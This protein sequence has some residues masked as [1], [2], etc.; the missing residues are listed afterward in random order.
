MASKQVLFQAN[1]VEVRQ[2]AEVVRL[3]P[4][5]IAD[6]L[7]AIINQMRNQ[8]QEFANAS[9]FVQKQYAITEFLDQ[10]GYN[11]NQLKLAHLDINWLVNFDA[12]QISGSV[13]YKFIV[14]AA[15]VHQIILD[16]NQLYIKSVSL[17]NVENVNTSGINR[18]DVQPLKFVHSDYSKA[19]FSAPLKILLEQPVR[20][21]EC[22]NV[23]VEYH[24]VAPQPGIESPT[25]TAIQWLDKEQTADKTHPYMFTQ[26]QAIHCRSLL[27]CFDTPAVKFT[28]TAQVNVKSSGIQPATGLTALMSASNLSQTD[29][30]FMFEQKVPIPSYLIALLVGGVTSMPYS[31]HSKVWSEPSMIKQ[32]AHEFA[33]SQKYL[34]RAQI[35]T[36]VQYAWS[37]LDIVVLPPS[38]PYGG[39][40]NTQLT[41][42]TNSIVAGDRSLVDV[43]AHEISHSWAG[44]LVGCSSWEHFWLNEGWC[45]YLE[46]R[47]LAFKSSSSDNS[48]GGL[49]EDIRQFSAL[50]GWRALKESCKQMEK[51]GQL[52]LTK[53]VNN[54]HGV[55]PDDAFSSVPYEKGFALLYHIEQKLGL[56][57]FNLYMKDYFK[58][59]A[60]QAIDTQTWKDHLYEFVQQLNKPEKAKALDGI[61]WDSWLNGTGMPLQDCPY[62]SKFADDCQKLCDYWISYSQT[63]GRNND[64]N[65]LDV[66]EWNRW[67]FV[68]FLEQLLDAQSPLTIKTLEVMMAKL[69]LSTDTEIDFDKCPLMRNSEIRFR[70]YML[71]L[72]AQWTVVFGGVEKFLLMYGRMKFVR[73]LMRAL[74][75]CGEAGRKLA[76]NAL[77]SASYHSICASLVA[78]DLKVKFE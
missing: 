30:K 48:D 11:Y 8:D 1:G 66:S 71:C 49:D 36:G 16:T 17:Q 53:L 73:P 58:T 34:E 69:G 23:L 50:I 6:G 25:T 78:K 32:C 77:K 47:V 21:G 35:L 5:Q 45:M 24:T 56:E 22:L 43:V 13:Q 18:A 75:R 40:E 37:N 64:D 12:K 10:Q 27:P 14:S 60:K 67:Q 19:H 59:F 9:D 15:E 26:C 46:R 28:W 42:L 62:R 38:F 41:F 52:Q 65:M 74:D 2:I 70:W 72:N 29:G 4:N 55:D 44:N 61:N 3:S 31:S 68:Y 63:D 7:N 76:I 39:M 20:Q 57:T 51:S 54:L 33:E